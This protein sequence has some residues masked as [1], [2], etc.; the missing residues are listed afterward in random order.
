MQSLFITFNALAFP[1]SLGSGCFA[2]SDDPAL[3]PNIH[4][5]EKW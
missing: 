1:G 2:G 5:N 3:V 4:C